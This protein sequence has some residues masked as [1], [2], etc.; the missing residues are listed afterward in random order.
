MYKKERVHD[1]NGRER[2]RE[3]ERM[4]ERKKEPLREKSPH[5]EGMIISKGEKERKR[6]RKKHAEREIEE[7]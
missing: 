1:E 2:D 6:W 4:G 5:R 7:G 3:R